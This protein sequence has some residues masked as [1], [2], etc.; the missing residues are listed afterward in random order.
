M[1][2][3]ATRI[4][5]RVRGPLLTVAAALLLLPASA[6]RAS[7]SSAASQP[8][9]DTVVV[10]VSAESPVVELPRQHLTD[11][12]LGRTSRFPDGRGAAPIDLEPGAPEREEFYERYLGRNQAEIKTHWSRLVFTGRGRPPPDLESGERV[13][14]RVADDP[15]AIGYI[16]AEL[17]DGS[18]R[19]VRIR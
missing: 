12:Y 10:V 16:D 6:L 13:R 1:D 9:A 11:L 17:V 3:R 14:E 2:R 7:P 19:I 8:A 18:V 4:R 15:S 5:P